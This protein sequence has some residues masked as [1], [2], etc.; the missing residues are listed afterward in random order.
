ALEL[1]DLGEMSFQLTLINQE[2]AGGQ[3]L[4]QA[5][6]HALELARRAVANNPDDYRNQLWLGQVAFLAKQLQEAEKAFREAYRL[7]GNVPETQ[8]ALLLFLASTDAKKAEAEL[9]A[10]KAQAQQEPLP[11]VTASYYEAAGRLEDA[12][13][14]HEAALAA[15]PGDVTVLANAAGFYLRTRQLAKA[16]PLLRKLIDP[17]TKAPEGTVS[18]A[19]RNLALLLSLEGGYSRFREAIAL[20]DKNDQDMETQHTR[21]LVLA[22]QSGFRRDALRLL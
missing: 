18:A 2:G 14:Q 7:A 17:D 15:R 1:P 11:A 21:A 8:A 3:A 9:A 22:T 6:D 4:V 16:E 5:R 12:A 20:L 19:R 13:A 10:I